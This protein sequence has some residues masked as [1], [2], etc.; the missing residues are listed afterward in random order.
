MLQLKIYKLFFSFKIAQK[1]VKIFLM[2]LQEHYLQ[3]LT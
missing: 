1:V 3:F 2:F